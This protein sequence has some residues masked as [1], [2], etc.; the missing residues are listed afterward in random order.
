MV[1]AKVDIKSFIKTIGTKEFLEPLEAL[2]EQ[3]GDYDISVT[4]TVVVSGKYITHLGLAEGDPSRF[5]EILNA[6]ANLQ[7][8]S[9][10]GIK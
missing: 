9:S 7:L 6:V 10:I 2:M 5:I 8:Y 1:D 4:P 3:Q